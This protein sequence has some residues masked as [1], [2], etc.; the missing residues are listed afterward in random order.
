MLSDPETRRRYDAFGHDF[1]QVP[2][3][4]DP[5]TWARAP[6][7]AAG[8]GARAGGGPGERDEW[9][10]DGRHRHRR[11]LRRH[12]RSGRRGGRGDRSRA[13]T[14][15]PS[16][17]LTVEEAYRGGQRTITLAG[18]DGPRSY[19]GHDP[20]GRHRRSAHPAGRPGRAGHRRRR[21]RRPLPRRAHR[22]AP[23]LPGRGPRH[24]RRPAAGAVG[25]GARRHG[26]RSTRPAAKRRCGSRRARRAGGGCGCAGGACRTRSGEP[27]DLYAEVRI[28]V[29]RNAHRRRAPAV[30]GAGRD[31][32]LRSEETTM[33]ARLGA[34]PMP[35]R[36]RRLRPSCRAAPRARAPLRRAR[37][38]RGAPDPPASCGSPPPSSPPRRG[39]SACAPASPSTTPRSAWSSTCSTASP[40]LEAAHARTAPTIREARRG[41]E[42]ADP[43]VPG[44]A[45]RR[46]DQ[47]AALRP[48]RGRRRAPAARTA[49]PA[50]RAGAA[51][52]RAGRRR[53]RRAARQSRPSWRGGRGSPARARRPV[54]SSSRSAW[55][56][57][58]T[59]P[60]R[61]PSG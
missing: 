57:C 40:Q 54:R 55:R 35:A 28:M 27:G 3:G 23:P 61:R 44:S 48:H 53:P 9:F 24:L 56:A 17:T 30:R 52:A 41:H 4:V 31:V 14:R 22:A 1:R 20:A 47:G 8:A 39:S 19:R 21:G 59:P 26:R 29:P 58:S 32:D 2:E 50:R 11:S 6:A 43:E 7:P 60:S 51:A 38:A 15:K 34:V 36:P 12:V 25:G 5:E 16:S 46:A 49:R 37:A 45:A 33:T 13:P 42:P 18:P 10:D